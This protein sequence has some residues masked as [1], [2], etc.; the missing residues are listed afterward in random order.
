MQHDWSHSTFY[1]AQNTSARIIALLSR[2][3]SAAPVPAETEHQEELVQLLRELGPECEIICDKLAARPA[4]NAHDLDELDTRLRSQLELAEEKL[5][6]ELNEL[7]QY[8][9]KPVCQAQVLAEELDEIGR[10]REARRSGSAPSE[11]KNVYERARQ[12]NLC[13]LALSGGGIRS[14]TFNLGLLQGMAKHRVLPLIDYLSMVS[15]GGY[16]GGWLAAWIKRDG[17]DAV[18]KSLADEESSPRAAAMR[19]LAFLRDY[20]SYLTPQTGLFSADTWAAFMTWFRNTF[21]NLIILLSG[22]GALLLIPR[23]VKSSLLGLQGWLHNRSPLLHYPEESLMLIAVL[24]EVIII[25]HAGRNLEQFKN[26]HEDGRANGPPGFGYS[27]KQVQHWIIVPALVAAALGSTRLW[28][29]AEELNLRPGSDGLSTHLLGLAAMVLACFT[30]LAYLQWRGGFVECYLRERRRSAGQLRKARFLCFFLPFLV[31]IVKATLLFGLYTL[32][33]YVYRKYPCT[34]GEY[35]CIRGS[36]AITCGTPTML[37]VFAVCLWIHMGLMGRNLPDDRREWW[38]TIAAYLGIY[39]A[40]ISAIFAVSFFGPDIFD[41][42]AKLRGGWG[43]SISILGWAFTTAGGLFFAQRKKQEQSNSENDWK[44][45]IALRAFIALSPAVFVAGL[46]IVLSKWL[47]LV[48]RATNAFLEKPG[49]LKSLP[50]PLQWALSRPHGLTGITIPNPLGVLFYLVFL[51][52][53]TFGF[54]FTVD[55]NEFSM[56][57]FYRNRLIRAYL[58]ASH[59][60]DRYPNRLTGFD[61][62]DDLPLTSLRPECEPGLRNY[63]RPYIGPYPLFNAALNLVHGD[64]LSWQERKATSFVCTPKF[65]GYDYQPADDYAIVPPLRDAGF[66]PTSV[67]AYPDGGIHVGTAMAISGAALSPNSGSYTSTSLAFLLTVF[68]VRLGWW[69][70]NPRNDKSWQRSG[71]RFG[72]V[73]LLYELFG[74]TNDRQKH[75]YLSDGGH[76]DNLGVYEL[77]R[78]RCSLIIA[79]DAEED[80]DCSFHGLGAVIRKCFID[81]GVR[82]DVNL[83]CIRPKSESFS[84]DHF[85]IGCIHYPEGWSGTFLYIKSSLSGDEPADLKEYM[86]RRQAFP[87]QS[88]ADQFFDESEFESYHRLGLHI[89]KCVFGPGTPAGMTAGMKKIRER[90][91]AAQDT[92]QSKAF[93]IDDTN[94]AAAD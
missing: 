85:A 45:A 23:L 68:N 33:Q 72:L 82:I 4:P 59:C 14:A 18:E 41:K 42:I 77:V 16:I 6:G 3:R 25:V 30:L 74:W 26:A 24:C 66:R 44:S 39:A 35:S 75:V 62:T 22:L 29:L 87:N 50:F 81:F 58:G 32:F 43:S 64:R 9:F 89:A 8:L 91:W 36:I 28:G 19:P 57:H 38:S 17:F 78:R 70:G 61:E 10:L 80:P 54:A 46:F 65:C 56:H 40:G 1:R 37:A 20:A 2:D 90:C 83:D 92:R 15:G 94:S 76:F 27:P 60:K 84:G 67:Y 52:I 55:I 31:A 49:L 11:A 13:G 63:G 5:P 21:L 51:L 69:M 79:S 93:W 12:S 88:T 73:Y 7:E 86:A 47:D 71:P 34:P 48:L 53:V